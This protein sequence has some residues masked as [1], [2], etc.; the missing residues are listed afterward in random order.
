MSNQ[1]FHASRVFKYL[2]LYLVPETVSKLYTI[3]DQKQIINLNHT[4]IG[5]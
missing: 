3:L 2:D 4:S 1:I 5:S